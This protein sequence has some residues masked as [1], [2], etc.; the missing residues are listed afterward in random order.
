[1]HLFWL[2]ESLLP[3]VI[4]QLRC[5]PSL[6]RPPQLWGTEFQAHVGSAGSLRAPEG[7]LLCLWHISMKPPQH[8]TLL[9]GPG[10][11]PAAPSARRTPNHWDLP[12]EVPRPLVLLPGEPHGQGSLVGMVHRSKESDTTEATWQ[13]CRVACKVCPHTNYVSSHSHSLS[14]HLLLLLF[15]IFAGS[16]G[17]YLCCFTVFYTYDVEDIFRCLFWHLNVF[18]WD[19]YI[20]LFC[21][22]LKIGVYFPLYWGW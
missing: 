21:L 18:W 9:G 7:R 22:V 10:I 20:K 16:V 11:E 19:V 3:C 12:K 8:G 1:M 4:F 13:G 15:W 5:R 2:F 17:V 6:R 14:I